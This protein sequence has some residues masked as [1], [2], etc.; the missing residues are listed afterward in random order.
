MTQNSF[1][2]ISVKM[3][4][5][6]SEEHVRFLGQIDRSEASRTLSNI[7]NVSA[8]NNEN[9]FINEEESIPTQEKSIVRTDVRENTSMKDCFEKTLS[10]NQEVLFSLGPYLKSS[11]NPTILNQAEIPDTNSGSPIQNKIRQSNYFFISD[12]ETVSLEDEESDSNKD[13]VDKILNPFTKIFPAT[14]E[15]QKSVVRKIENNI[16][17][18]DYDLNE[19]SS[20]DFEIYYEKNEFDL[21][22]EL[23]IDEGFQT[24]VLNESQTVEN[25]CL[26][27]ENNK[28]TGID[29]ESKEYKFD[30]DN[31]LNENNV[32]NPL[33]RFKTSEDQDRVTKILESCE[34]ETRVLTQNYLKKGKIMN[35]TQVKLK[36]LRVVLEKIDIK[37]KSC[38]SE[39]S[40]NQ[41]NRESNLENVQTSEDQCLLSDRLNVQSWNRNSSINEEN[42]QSINEENEISVDERPFIIDDE[43]DKMISQIVKLNPITFQVCS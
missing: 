3:K 13:E 43:S 11:Q 36:D 31:F 41:G 20:S 12:D 38:V 18:V 28:I 15:N 9:M 22:N 8:N 5:I 29:K 34:S 2:S 7:E 21:R 10:G 4:S 14:D 19:E 1:N 17:L 24:N 32:S 37:S 26:N 25:N 39:I 35:K 6:E 42:N 23:N 16:R 40:K 33:S 30:L 27:V